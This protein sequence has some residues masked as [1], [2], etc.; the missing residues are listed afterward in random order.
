M[1]ALRSDYNFHYNTNMIPMDTFL[2][3]DNQSISI[4]PK[5]VYTH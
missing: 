1:I 2:Y 3:T 5:Y 4:V